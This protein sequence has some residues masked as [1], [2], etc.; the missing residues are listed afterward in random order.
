MSNELICPI[1]GKPTSVYM[2]N[3]RKDRL[4]KEHAAALKAGK[5][6]QC[7]ICG[8]WHNAGENCACSKQKK[9]DNEKESLSDLTCIICGNDSNGKHFCLSCYRKYKD[10]SIDI[11]ILNCRDTI[12][13]DEYGNKTK[14]TKDGRSVRSLSEKIIIDYF[15]D[16]YIRAVYEKTIPYINEKGEEACLHPDFYLPDY[17]L[18]I[19]FN[20][21]TNKHYLKMKNYANKIY[22]QKG[23]NVVILE[24]QDIDDIEST[25]P[26]I[27]EKYKK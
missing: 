2:G 4:C 6:E 22:E 15:F 11:R 17:N 23:Y 12:V 14:K 3:A 19:E 7:D 5:I 21:L 8:A 25:L 24:S 10:R 1:C 20:G 9:K 18:Y 27:L 13:I 26:R 16:N